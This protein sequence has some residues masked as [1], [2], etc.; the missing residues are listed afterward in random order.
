[1][2]SVSA[3]G[4]FAG[5]IL[6]DALAGK[7]KSD[8]RYLMPEKYYNAFLASYPPAANRNRDT[9]TNWAFEIEYG[10]PKFMVMTLSWREKQAQ[11]YSEANRFVLE[12]RF[13]FDAANKTL[14][15]ARVDRAVSM[16]IGSN[17]FAIGGLY[18]FPGGKVIR[19]LA[20]PASWLSPFAG[21]V[22]AASFSQFSGQT[23]GNAVAITAYAGG[24]F[25][26]SGWQASPFVP[27]LV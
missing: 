6:A 15:S 22:P 8:Q 17:G 3:L 12:G 27:N 11:P 14:K 23:Q 10:N 7:L 9:V 5:L 2:S 20:K 19:D 21:A 4:S 18:E 26:G 16:Q 1:M 24:R 13:A 25:F